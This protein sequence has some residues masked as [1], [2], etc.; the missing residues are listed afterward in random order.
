MVI[1]NI[2]KKSICKNF[3][4]LLN[5]SC[6]RNE[7]SAVRHVMPL[8]NTP[9]ACVNRDNENKSLEHRKERVEEIAKMF[10]DI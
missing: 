3:F 6:E 10:P 1:C 9:V 4:K 2:L 8:N 7:C 5:E